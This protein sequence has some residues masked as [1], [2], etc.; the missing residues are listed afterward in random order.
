MIGLDVHDLENFGDR[1]SY[2]PHRSRSSQFGTAYLRLDLDMMENMVVTIEP[3]FYVVPEILNDATLRSRF[4]E[5]I[6]WDRLDEWSNFGGIR[7][8]DNVRCTTAAPEILTGMIPKE[9][10]D[11]EHLVGNS[12]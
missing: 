8:E 1:A 4:Q 10:D 6:H 3:G 5:A 9:I 7:I 12:Q 2:P 11:I